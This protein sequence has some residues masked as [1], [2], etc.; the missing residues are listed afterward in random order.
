MVW[1]FGGLFE[2]DRWCMFQQLAADICLVSADGIFPQIIMIGI[3]WEVGKVKTPHPPDPPL[4]TALLD[5]RI[6]W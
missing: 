1:R 3:D 6:K 5:I 4:G 2:L